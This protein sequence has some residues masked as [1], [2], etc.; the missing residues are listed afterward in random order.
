MTL[1]FSNYL[2]PY[3]HLAVQVANLGGTMPFLWERIEEVAFE[4]S[5]AVPATMGPV[6]CY[7]DTASFGPRAIEMAVACF[8]ANR[9]LLGTDCPIFNTD[10]LLKSVSDARLDAETRERILFRNARQIFSLS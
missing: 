3:P 8:G 2:E 9:V 6:R 10:R 7:V 4:R 5:A 1:H